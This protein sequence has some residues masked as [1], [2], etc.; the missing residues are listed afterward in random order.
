MKIAI[1]GSGIAGNTIA[2][3]LH[4]E[5][6]ITVF[7]A[8]DYIGGHTH[9]HQIRYEGQ[10]ISVDTGF[11]VFNDRTYPNFIALLDELGVAWRSSS[12]SFSVRCEDTGLEYNGTTLNS[13]FAQRIN[14]F[15]PSFHRMIRDILKFNKN[16]LE[17]L[18]D[19]SE[20]RLGDYLKH[21][22]YSQQ[23]IDYYIIP[24]GSAIWST[25]A[26]QMLDF[27]ARFFVRF[28]HNH[29]MLTVND[30]PEWRTI[31]GGSDNYVEALTKPFK[32]S[33]RLNTP[34]ENVRRLQ[35]AVILKPK[36][37]EEERFDYV[38]FACHSNQALN[39]LSDKSSAEAEVLG[40]IPYQNN[41][42]FLHHDKTLLPKRR[43]AWAAWNY[44]V[45]NPASERVAVT[46]NM[47]ILQGLQTREPLLVTLNHTG[48]ID[49]K[50]VIKRID[51]LHPVY[52]VA[53]SAAQAR[54]AEISGVNRTGFA[55]AYWHNGFHEDGVVSALQALKHFER[56]C[57][58]KR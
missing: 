47:N 18:K 44:H 45:T 53:G 57:N 5:H 1:I 4:K 43:L 27:P 14:L 2:Y 50:K 9:T 39:I 25:D 12:M 35:D 10:A 28:F 17:L 20:I 38:F 33:I 22:G 40:A 32:Q 21:G 8:N 41:T 19:G 3:K 52:T 30:R 54:H 6:D 48:K 58:G 55:G 49:P 23:F 7:E 56:Y 29:G 36:F 26:K 11:I 37:S 34:V 42:V 46:Y 24:M 13:L 15:K 51:Y 31:A 16:S